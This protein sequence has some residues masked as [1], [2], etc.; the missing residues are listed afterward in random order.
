MEDAVYDISAFQVL[1][2]YEKRNEDYDSSD[3]EGGDNI[4]IDFDSFFFLV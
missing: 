4:R 1:N 2:T 3:T